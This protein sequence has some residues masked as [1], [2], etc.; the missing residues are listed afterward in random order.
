MGGEGYILE[1]RRLL[2]FLFDRL[3]RGLIGRKNVV[4]LRLV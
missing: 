3:D 2:G 1:V 4:G